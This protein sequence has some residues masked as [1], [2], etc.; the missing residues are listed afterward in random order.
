VIN[1]SST[2]TIAAQPERVFQVF[3][4]F[5]AM[6][7]RIKGIKRLEMLTPGP[8]RV[9]TRFRETRHMHGHDATEE[10]EITAFDRPR[11]YAVSCRS[12]GSLIT[13]TFRFNRAA[14]GTLV[15]VEIVAQAQSWFAK[16][17]S[18]LGKMLTGMIQKCV[19]QDILD[20]KQL[21]EAPASAVV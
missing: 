19:T 2:H 8:L 4:D 5:G 9:G 13:T 6:P 15:A 21:L 1:C 12:C 17:L 20:L 7:G 3:S 16:L 18:P 14:Q 11:M 10:M